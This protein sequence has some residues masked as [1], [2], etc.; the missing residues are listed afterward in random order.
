MVLS[1]RRNHAKVAAADIDDAP[2][3]DAPGDGKQAG[4]G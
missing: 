2:A 4:E 3:D 1:A